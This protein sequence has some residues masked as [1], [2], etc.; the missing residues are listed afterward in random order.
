MRIKRDD[1]SESEEP[2]KKLHKS[3]TEHGK[4][5]ESDLSDSKILLK[6]TEPR[7][8]TSTEGETSVSDARHEHDALLT[9]I[10]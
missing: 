10:F 3:C 8:D 2:A 9:E 6:T 4:D 1:Q 7:V 5:A